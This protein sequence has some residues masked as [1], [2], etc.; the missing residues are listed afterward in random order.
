MQ[1]LAVV[2]ETHSRFV[3]PKRAAAQ[4]RSLTWFCH[5]WLTIGQSKDLKHRQRTT[6]GMPV[7]AP[8]LQ[9]LNRRQYRLSNRCWRTIA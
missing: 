1:G 5:Q 2:H 6:I 7:E 3:V 9:L 4:D 8:E